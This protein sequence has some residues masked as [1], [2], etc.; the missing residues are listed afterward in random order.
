MIN[1]RVKKNTFMSLWC[2]SG[3]KV[4]ESAHA[5]TTAAAKRKVRQVEAQLQ[6]ASSQQFT[7]FWINAVVKPPFAGPAAPSARYAAPCAELQ[8]GQVAVKGNCVLL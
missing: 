8:S 5:Q 7:G 1:M 2:S 4:S 6:A 3:N